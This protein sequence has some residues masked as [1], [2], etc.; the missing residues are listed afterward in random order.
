MVQTF[1]RVHRVGDFSERKVVLRVEKAFQS[2]VSAGIEPADLEEKVSIARSL[3]EA[4]NG[5]RESGVEFRVAV[6]HS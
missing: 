6:G 5:S 4:E 2:A 3:P 1:R